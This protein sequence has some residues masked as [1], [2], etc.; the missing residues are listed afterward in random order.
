MITT[1][2]ETNFYLMSNTTDLYAN[3]LFYRAPESYVV[4]RTFQKIID[5]FS[6]VGGLLGAILMIFIIVNFYNENAYEMV[7]A[8]SLYKP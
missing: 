4:N 6:Y 5:S 3:L 8:A 1:L 7:C 2:V